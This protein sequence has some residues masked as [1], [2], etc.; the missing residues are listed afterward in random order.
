MAARGPIIRARAASCVKVASRRADGGMVGRRT[1]RTRRT[2]TGRSRAETARITLTPRRGRRE[3]RPPGPP[4][5]ARLPV[6]YR[7]T[8]GDA[9]GRELSAHLIALTRQAPRIRAARGEVRRHR[10]RTLHDAHVRTLPAHA[11]ILQ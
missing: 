7:W 9:I 2:R 3:R 10:R 4:G 11:G 8:S 1:A 6:C 5:S